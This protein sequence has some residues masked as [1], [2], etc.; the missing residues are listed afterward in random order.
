MF[1][2]WQAEQAE[3]LEDSSARTTVFCKVLS[4][5]MFLSFVMINLQRVLPRQFSTAEYCKQTEKHIQRYQLFHLSTSLIHFLCPSGDGMGTG[6][7]F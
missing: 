4:I 1:L 6:K 5:V 3:E 2:V 7:I